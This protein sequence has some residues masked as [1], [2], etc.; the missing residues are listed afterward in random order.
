MSI[1]H[2]DPHTKEYARDYSNG[3]AAS[4]RPSEGSALE[5]ADGRGVSHAW[6]DGYSDMA[7]GREKWTWRTWRRN[8]CTSNCGDVCN[9]PHKGE[10]S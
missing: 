2:I 10:V 1:R 7:C 9:G 6:Y 4:A 3:W 8:G 5:R